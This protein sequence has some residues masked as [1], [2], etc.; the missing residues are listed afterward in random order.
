MYHSSISLSGTPSIN[1]NRSPSLS[2]LGRARGRE[3]AR[4]R[5]RERGE[6][7]ETESERVSE[8]E[9]NRVRAGK[10]EGVISNGGGEG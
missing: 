7:S 4:E 6:E 9:G 2:V 1:L 10:R 3:R 8:S 5:V